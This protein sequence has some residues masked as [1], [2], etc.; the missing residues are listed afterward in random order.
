MARS[1]EITHNEENKGQEGNCEKEPDRIGSEK[2]VSRCSSIRHFT[3]KK[4]RLKNLD[5]R[6][7]LK[8]NHICYQK[9]LRATSL[10][11]RPSFKVMSRLEGNRG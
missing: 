8:H 11:I 1:E 7:S 2:G 5:I 10:P 6:M 9:L 3:V 4:R